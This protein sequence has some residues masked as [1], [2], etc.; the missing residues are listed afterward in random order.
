MYVTQ[1]PNDIVALD[2]RTG[3]VFW[4]YRYPTSPGHRACCGS[5]NRGVAMLGDR[6][7]MAT[8][9]AHVVAVDA[10]TGGELWNVEVADME[11]AYAFTLAPLAIKDKVIVGTT[12]GDRGIRGFIAAFDAETGEE[13]VALPYHSRARRTGA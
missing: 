10:T 2:A 4:I 5:N 1:R 9:D 6:L 7:F 12:G 8:L 3:R 11:L 13:G